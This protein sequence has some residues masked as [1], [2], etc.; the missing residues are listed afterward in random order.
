MLQAPNGFGKTL[1]A[2]HIVQRA[3]DKSN[4]T[5]ITVPALSLGLVT[6]I[7]H[8]RLDDGEPRRRN[9]E[10][11]D[12][13]EPLPRLCDDCKAVIPRRATRCPECGA[14]REAKSTVVHQDG[15]LIELGSGRTSTLRPTLE[16]RAAFFGELKWIAGERGYTS[17]WASHKF[18][19]K[20]GV[21]P[22]D[23]R[24]KFVVPTSPS[25]KTKNWVRS[26]QI[27]FAK[28]RAHG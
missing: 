22:N 23:P 21:W 13:S 10:A 12:R 19:E 14:I 16:D 9:A 18:K 3:L 1:T 20:F 7:H 8:D 27:A 28:A 2:A 25:L 4:R 26:R 15:E 6:D 24:V 17:G 5:I 11:D